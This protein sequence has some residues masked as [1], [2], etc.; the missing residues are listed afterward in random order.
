VNE[1]KIRILVLDRGFVMVCRCTSPEQYGFWLPVYDARIVR[2][3]GTS[4]GLAELCNGPR[5]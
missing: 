3:W 2:A 4:N 1:Q 5:S